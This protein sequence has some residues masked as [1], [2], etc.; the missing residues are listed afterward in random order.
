MG[1]LIRIASIGKLPFHYPILKD[2]LYIW[3]SI[4]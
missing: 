4:G 2:I 1:E 3:L